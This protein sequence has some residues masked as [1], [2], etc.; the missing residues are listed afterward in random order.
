MDSRLSDIKS[1]LETM[2]KMEIIGQFAHM[3][4]RAET[5]LDN[6]LEDKLAPINAHLDRIEAKL[7]AK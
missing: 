2:F 5:R 6:V 7:G 4:T 3:E 1:V